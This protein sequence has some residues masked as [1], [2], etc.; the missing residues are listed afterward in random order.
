MYALNENF[1][2]ED[3]LLS[4]SDAIHARGMYLMLDVVANHMASPGSFNDTH[5]KSFNPFNSSAYFHSPCWPDDSNTTSVQVCMTGDTEGK[6]TLADLRT[7]DADVR[8]ILGAWIQDTVDKY[9][10]DGLRLDSAKAIEPEFWTGFLQDAGVFAMA[11]YFDGDPAVFPSLLDTLPGAMNYPVF[12]WIQRSL[13]SAASDLTELMT[14]MRTMKSTMKTRTLG[15]FLDNNDQ[16]R[17]AAVAPDMAITKNAMAFTYVA[18]DGFPVVYYGTEQ[19]FSGVAEPSNRQNLWSSEYRTDAELYLWIRKLNS[20]RALVMAT[21]SAYIPYQAEPIFGTSNNGNRTANT[22][23]RVQT[24]AVKKS[25]VVSVITNVG[26]NGASSNI[27]LDASKTLYVADTVYVDLISC[28]RF[29]TTSNGQLRFEMRD[30]PRIFFPASKVDAQSGDQDCVCANSAPSDEGSP[31]SSLCLV[32]FNVTATTEFGESVEVLGDAPQLG[33]GDV[34]Q[35]VA[36]DASQY[37]VWT[38]T[39]AMTAAEDVSYQF[40]KINSEGEVSWDGGAQGAA[41][42]TQRM[43]RVCRDRTA[44][45]TPSQSWSDS[46][47]AALKPRLI[48]RRY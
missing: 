29:K 2:T 44:V 35:A 23:E 40:L 25:D 38:V 18:A 46:E 47:A 34:H 48:R 8:Q 17:W 11:E 42:K 31:G 3:D 24:M 26:L 20:I 27:T 5:W 30:M 16:K 32:T 14:G 36:L 10:V 15:M 1:G 13:A 45:V 43:P 41:V 7:E 4:L 6:V 37:P 21:D 9:Q 33:N 39:V 28:E 12:Y 22:T 19:H